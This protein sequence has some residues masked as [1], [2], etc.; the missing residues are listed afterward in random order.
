MT[1]S[2]ELRFGYRRGIPEGI[3]TAWGARLIAPDDLVWDRQDLVAE[4]D[5]DKAALIEWLNG[6]AIAKMREALRER[7]SPYGGRYHGESEI[8]PTEDRE[9]VL[10]QDETGIIVGNT[11]ASH[12]YVYVSG[13][14]KPKP[15]VPG[16][17]QTNRDYYD[18]PDWDEAALRTDQAAL[19]E[20]RRAT[21][22]CYQAI[23]MP[24]TTERWHTHYGWSRQEAEEFG[25]SSSEVRV[26]AVYTDGSR[27]ELTTERA[28]E[29]EFG[30]GGS[31]PHTTARAIV[32]DVLGE[33]SD[34]APASVRRMVP[35]A[36]VTGPR[37]A[38]VLT[39]RAQ[40]VRERLVAA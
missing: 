28:G 10:Y 27:R 13:W 6:G 23:R 20:I 25:D 2:E 38:T 5:E 21:V 24:I 31:G 34:A 12:G 37:D 22:E 7:Y 14:L 16:W 39:V 40:D 29:F 11:N 19:R 30:Y 36:F 15:S 33:A 32:S 1:L 3:T 9:H 18:E 35:E 4:S 17:V 26:F 8:V